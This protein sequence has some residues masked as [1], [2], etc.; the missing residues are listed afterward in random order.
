MLEVTVLVDFG[1]FLCKKPKFAFSKASLLSS[2]QSMSI[3]IFWILAGCCPGLNLP[4]TVR[5]STALNCSSPMGPVLIHFPILRSRMSLPSSP[6]LPARG[7]FD[8]SYWFRS[9]LPG[10]SRM[11]YGIRCCA[12]ALFAGSN[13][14]SLLTFRFFVLTS[15]WSQLNA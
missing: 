14:L 7:I 5:G 12:G 4:L 2:R 3:P 9:I 6:I 1:T 8:A 15:Y 11:F 10:L 13:M